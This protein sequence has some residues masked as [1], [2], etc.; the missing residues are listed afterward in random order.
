MKTA[1]AKKTRWSAVARQIGPMGKASRYQL[2]D[3]A[4]GKVVSLS[5]E[6]NARLAAAAPKAVELLNEVE[7]ILTMMHMQLNSALALNTLPPDVLVK[8]RA[9]LR[10]EVQ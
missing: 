6:K 10:H 9:F 7:Q 2:I 8:I 3:D 1:K 5:K 4:T